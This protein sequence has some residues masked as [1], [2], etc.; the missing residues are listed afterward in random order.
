MA[1]KTI[2][3]GGDIVNAGRIKLVLNPPK[4]AEEGVTYM[5]HW[6][7]AELDDEGNFTVR[8]FGSAQYGS[9]SLS[10]HLELTDPGLE[11]IKEMLAQVLEAYG[12]HAKVTAMSSA[13]TARKF[14]LDQGESLTSK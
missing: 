7:R 1:D 2:G 3:Q 9:R 14:A 12:E 8:L 10:D 4:P 6:V 5:G 13:F 11:P